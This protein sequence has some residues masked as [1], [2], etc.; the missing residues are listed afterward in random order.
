MPSPSPSSLA[1]L[2]PARLFG[3]IVLRS[4]T[5]S[6]G[7]SPGASGDSWKIPAPSTASLPLIVLSITVVSPVD[8][9]P[10]P[11]AVWG[12]P[13]LPSLRPAELDELL[14]MMKRWASVL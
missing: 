2:V 10:P 7:G 3:P 8:R 4:T 1:A 12:R 6:T 9:S 13:P 14:G 5:R 11:T